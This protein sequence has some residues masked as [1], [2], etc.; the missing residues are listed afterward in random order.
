MR[1]RRLE[2]AHQ[3][4]IQHMSEFVELLRTFQHLVRE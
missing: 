3:L 2:A 1:M 4:G